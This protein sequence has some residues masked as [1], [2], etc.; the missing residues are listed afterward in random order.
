MIS[1]GVAVILTACSSSRDAGPIQRSTSPPTTT[2]P[3]SSATETT[4][5]TAPATA[6]SGVA[7]TSTTTTST[8][9]TTSTTATGTITGTAIAG[10][11]GAVEA[12]G[13]PFTQTDPFAEAVRLSD[14]TCV[15]WADSR[16][17]S[18][19]GLAAGA[20]VTILDAEANE[21]IGSGTIQSSRWEDMA[22]GGEQ[23]NCLFDF[24]ATITGSPAEF[25]VRVGT[26]EPWLA[27]PDPTAPGT[28]VASV[29]TGASIGLIPSCP[30]VPGP[31]DGPDG[32]LDDGG[33]DHDGRGDHRAGPIVSRAGTPSA[34]TGRVGVDSLC[35]VGLPV[36]A[37][38]R[39]CRPAGV[40]SEYI[41]AVVD[42]DDSTVTYANGA[43]VPIGTEVTV[44]V[45]TGRRCG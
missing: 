14:G 17:G 44:V 33:V 30:A 1:I 23:W 12:S 29:S 8:T 31:E 26:L 3:G 40:G 5:D 7:T 35:S 6:S 18:T 16:G 19:A 11:V 9:S 38:A 37:I 27:R 20:A 34:S 28:F 39:P 13:P 2:P 4:G 21:E 43:A 24:T 22:G 10:T 25:R 36:T 15:G 42:S 41:A 45:A 32:E